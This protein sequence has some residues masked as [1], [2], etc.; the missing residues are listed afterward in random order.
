M[1]QQLHKVFIDAINALVMHK[2]QFTKNR[3]RSKEHFS[4]WRGP[5]QQKRSIDLESVHY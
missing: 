4:Y 3:E 5:F 2:R 1:F